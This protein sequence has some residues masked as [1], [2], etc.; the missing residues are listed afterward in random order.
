MS[1]RVR[2]S[3][4]C[5][6]TS[7]VSRQEPFLLQRQFDLDLLDCIEHLLSTCHVVARREN[8]EAADLLTDVAGQRIEKLQRLDL[9]VEQ[10]D[11]QGIVGAFRGKN[12][13]HVAVHAKRPPLELHIVALILHLG[14]PLDGIALRQLIALAQMQDHA[15]ILG[16]IADTVN[17]GH[18]A[19]DDAVR[20]LQDRLGRRQT[21]LLDVLVD[22]RI[23]FDIEVARRHVGFGLIVVV[24]R[25]EI[26]DRV[27]RQELA[28][29]GVELGCQRL[30]RS[31]HQRRPASARDD[32]GHCVGLAGTG[33]AEQRLE[34]QAVVDPF[35][36]LVDRF[37][38]IARRHERLMEFERAIRESGD[39]A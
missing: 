36:Q 16:R 27:V 2:C 13:E 9:I 18:G 15:V 19:D 10:R 20:P 26:L 37:G 7:L 23:L 30:V 11:A 31:Q 17:G 14:Q 39:H 35:D 28:E 38:L 24:V 8:G 12:V 33:D 34:R 3:M 29:L 6:S 21:H 25:D 32:V 4:R 1:N 22:R 5:A